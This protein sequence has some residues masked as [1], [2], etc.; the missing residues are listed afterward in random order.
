MRVSWPRFWR[1]TARW[2]IWSLTPPAVAKSYGDTSPTFMALRRPCPDP[3]GHMPLLGVGLN[4][5]L[6][7]AQ[8]PLR[9]AH[10]VGA[11]IACRFRVDQRRALG[12]V[13]IVGQPVDAHGKEWRAQAQRDRRRA[14][15]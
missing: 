14:E 1:C 9:C 4:E 6:D 10:L 11:R 5:L 2:R 8:H 7:A 12:H 3:M 13:G 15:R